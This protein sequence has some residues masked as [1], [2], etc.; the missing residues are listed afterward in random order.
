VITSPRRAPIRS[1]TASPVMIDAS[2]V[3][4]GASN[5]HDGRRSRSASESHGSSRS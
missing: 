5:R 3:H 2:G 4:Y 1:G